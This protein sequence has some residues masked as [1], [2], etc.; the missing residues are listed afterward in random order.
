MPVVLVLI[1]IDIIIGDSVTGVKTP[2]KN[3]LKE[4]WEQFKELWNQYSKS[5]SK[6]L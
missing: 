1:L 4:H 2:F 3:K 5:T 6:Q